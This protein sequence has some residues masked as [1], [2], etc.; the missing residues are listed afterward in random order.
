MFGQLSDDLIARTVVALALAT[1]LVAIAIAIDLPRSG[2][3]HHP[4]T[5]IASE[6]EF[7]AYMAALHEEAR[8]VA[9]IAAEQ[10]A[11]PQ[12]RS[13][14]SHLA[15]RYATLLEHLAH[16]GAPSE[17][18][19]WQPLLRTLTGLRPQEVDLLFHSD[20]Q[21]LHLHVMAL[22]QGLDPL[23]WSADG[24]ELAD[25]VEALHREEVAALPAL[26]TTP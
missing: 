19:A 3:R 21:A 10:G 23:D 13:H 15:S 9:T 24:R 7:L 16:L 14:A 2:D 4:S 12:L 22:M 1:A 11:D 20:M 25:R 18:G 8:G 17:H 26:H 6:A 5:E